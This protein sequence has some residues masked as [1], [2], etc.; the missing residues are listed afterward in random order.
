MKTSKVL[1]H[2]AT[3][4][5]LS[6]GHFWVTED[7][8]TKKFPTNDLFLIGLD[9]KTKKEVGLFIQDTKHKNVKARFFSK[10]TNIDI[11]FEIKNRIISAIEKRQKLNLI[12]ERENI[13]L[14]NAEADML[15]G[16]L[17]ILLKDQILIQFY[18]LYWNKFE[19]IIIESL[20]IALEKSYP[21]LKIADFWIQERTFDQ[22]KTIRSLNNSPMPEFVLNE[23]GIKYKMKIN[24]YYDYGIYTDMSA[25]RKSLRPF[26]EN[27]RNVLNLFCYT[28]AYS[29]YAMSLNAQKVTS[30]DLSDKYLSW[31]EE[32]I[33]LNSE[34]DIKKHISVNSSV[35]KALDKFIADEVKFDFILSD[36]PSSSSDGEK[37][38]NAFNAYEKLL[39]KLLDVLTIDGSL[40]VFLNTH[41]IS[42]TKFEE[43]LKLIISNTPF[44]DKV[45]VGKRFKL[46]ED[47]LPSKGFH[48]GDY[49]KGFLI[50]FKNKKV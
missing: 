25:I 11:D 9:S 5:H 49:L 15:P 24:A 4:K 10:E 32:N 29:L 30:V 13:L 41:Q 42:W 39:P 27:K 19:K 46:G 12:N 7:S 17:I 48:E 44:K 2:P 21:N 47:Y 3:I 45:I 28:G 1:L 35:E 8:F 36:P 23:F 43:K 50:E 37:R 6:N 20:K 18:A 31:L 38:D 22:K 16:L 34:L 26:I 14:V 40:V 33:H